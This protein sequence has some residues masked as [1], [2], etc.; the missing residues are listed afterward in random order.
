MPRNNKDIIDK[1]VEEDPQNIYMANPYIY[2]NRDSTPY[3]AKIDNGIL[4]PEIPEGHI[5]GYKPG[6]W[7]K[8]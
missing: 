7:F 6:D 8:I 4:F 5:K 1:F 3:I 2:V